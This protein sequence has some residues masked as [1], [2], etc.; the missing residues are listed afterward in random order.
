MNIVAFEI[1]VHLIIRPT[2]IGVW[3]KLLF[4]SILTD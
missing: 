3:R 2:T 4:L 1:H